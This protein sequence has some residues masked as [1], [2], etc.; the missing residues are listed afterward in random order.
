MKSSEPFFC[1][2]DL[3]FDLFVLTTRIPVKITEKIFFN[4]STLVRVW[5]WIIEKEWTSPNANIEKTS[6]AFK[7]SLNLP[8]MFEFG[9]LRK[10]FKLVFSVD[11]NEKALDGARERF[12]NF[13][14]LLL[15]NFT[16]ITISI[17]NTA[18]RTTSIAICKV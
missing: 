12:Q 5:I 16:L 11:F 4:N 13:P 18:E 17:A 14:G 9:S 15:I 7:D 2:V 10:V 6:N 3:A 8:S 1:D